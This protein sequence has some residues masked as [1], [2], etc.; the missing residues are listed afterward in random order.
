MAGQ[1]RSALSSDTI[2]G[3][4]FSGVIAFGL[5]MVSREKN[6]ARDIQRFVYG[7][8]LTIGDSDI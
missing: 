7:N 3:V 2:I 4:F 5:A 6:V 8:I 1:R